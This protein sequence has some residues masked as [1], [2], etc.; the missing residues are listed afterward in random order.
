[1]SCQNVV[2]GA[3]VVAL[4]CVLFDIHCTSLEGNY[5]ERISPWVLLHG[6]IAQW[7][8]CLSA[9]MCLTAD[10]GVVSLISA[11]S[12]T[13]VEVDHEIISTTILL[14]SANSRRIVVSY[15]YVHKV[16]VNRL[17]KLAQEKSVVR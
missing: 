1:M 17:V 11:Q 3:S 9:D 5:K 16:L 10:P 7:I 4:Q 2:M 14:F 15:K 12:H 6:R 8:R 13:F